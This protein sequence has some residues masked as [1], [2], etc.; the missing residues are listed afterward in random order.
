MTIEE[1]LIEIKLAKWRSISDASL[2]ATQQIELQIAILALQDTV[3]IKLLYELRGL[4][5]IA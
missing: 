3:I 1:L 5:K 4:Q 2:S